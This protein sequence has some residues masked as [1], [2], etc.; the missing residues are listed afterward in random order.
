[1]AGLKQTRLASLFAVFFLLA[2]IFTTAHIAAYGE[3][4]HS[5]D[6]HPCII[7]AAVKQADDLD[8]APASFSIEEQVHYTFSI[9]TE[10][11]SIAFTQ[12]ENLQARA[13]PFSLS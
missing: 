11:D 9:A 12:A 4:E 7:A 10:V 13:P 6:G 3:T 1:M 2:Q 5:H 8:C